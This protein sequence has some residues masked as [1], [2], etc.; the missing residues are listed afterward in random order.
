MNEQISGT[1]A[2]RHVRFAGRPAASVPRHARR[3]RSI[4]PAALPLDAIPSEPPGQFVSW[5]FERAGLAVEGYRGEPLARRL[6]ACLR[7][8]HAHTQDQ[9]RQILEARPELLPAAV[10][11]LLIGSTDFFRDAH[12][13]ETLRTDVLPKLA[14]GPLRIWS[15]GCSGGAELYSMAILLAE[16]GLLERSFL[17][18]SD[19]R[20][21]AIVEATAALFSSGNL[22]NISAPLRRKYFDEVGGLWRTVEPLHRRVQWK[23]ADLGRR[24]EPGPWDMIL[25]RNMAIYLKAE[26]AAAIW[27]GL[28]SVLS[29][30]GVLVAGRAE[31]PPPGLPLICIGRCIYLACPREGGRIRGPRTRPHRRRISMAWENSQ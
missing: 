9:A 23:V 7:T 2:L 12:V 26:A 6:P 17:L 8:L 11:A 25:W 29:P 27:Q 13:F 31:R 14:D 1:D 16:A 22:E 28:A 30:G 3:A 18:G 15:A 20:H 5:V 4:P 21:E 10:S 19:C 24:I